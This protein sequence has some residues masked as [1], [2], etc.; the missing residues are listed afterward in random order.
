MLNNTQSHARTRTHTHTHTQHYRNVPSTAL[1][2]GL[3]AVQILH[4]LMNIFRKGKTKTHKLEN[5]VF[6]LNET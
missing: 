3:V 6:N 1:T 2:S 5:G 4:L